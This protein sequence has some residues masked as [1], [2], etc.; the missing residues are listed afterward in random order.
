SAEVFGIDIVHAVE[1][2]KIGCF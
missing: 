1:F 2:S